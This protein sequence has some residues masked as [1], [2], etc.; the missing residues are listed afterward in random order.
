[1]VT[2]NRTSGDSGMGAAAAAPVFKTIATE[3]LR[4]LDV[5]KDIPEGLSASSKPAKDGIPPAADVSIA[6][7]DGGSV[8]E[9]DSSLKQLMAEQM[10]FQ[11]DPDEIPEARAGAVSL[12]SLAQA[13]TP[14]P[15]PPAGPTV[16]D[17]AA[18]P[19]AT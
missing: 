6:D 8:M 19:C 2:V 3:A 14:K 9:E 5:P 10:K 12:P 17:F 18:S 7:A 13:L 16:P 1:M 4:M 15:A 11:A